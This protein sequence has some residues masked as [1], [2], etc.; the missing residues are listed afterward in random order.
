MRTHRLQFRIVFGR[1]RSP[2]NVDSG[3]MARRYQVSD[4]K[5]LLTLQPEADGGFVVT[6]PIDPAMITQARTI[7]QAFVQARDAFAALAESR[8][9]AARWR[10]P[11][12]KTA[13]R[14]RNQRP[15]GAGI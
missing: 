13:A 9:D 15:V 5:L 8:A 12:K 1:L 11:A 4:G 3:P 10:L 2:N 6:S 14:T 7:E